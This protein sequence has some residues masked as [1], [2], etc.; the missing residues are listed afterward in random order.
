MTIFMLEPLLSSLVALM[1][2]P[3]L[4]D[5]ALAG[6]VLLG[7]GA[8][9]P[10][11]ALSGASSTSMG[12]ATIVLLI[13]MPG[14]GTKVV[15]AAEEAEP[16]RV[17]ATSAVAGPSWTVGPRTL[18]MVPLADALA[19]FGVATPSSSSLDEEDSSLTVSSVVARDTTELEPA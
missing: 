17:Q 18:A 7:G 11:G 10:A 5:I 4:P 1:L 16:K 15:M 6:G 3:E 9:G 19:L 2:R 8:K 13:M 12:D 14:Q